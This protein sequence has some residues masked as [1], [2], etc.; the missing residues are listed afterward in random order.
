MS[1][2]TTALALVGALTLAAQL[3]AQSPSAPGPQ[4]NRRAGPP[5]GPRPMPAPAPGMMGRGPDVA[6]QLLAHTGELKL[7]DQQV[8]RLA[9]IARRSADRREGM[10]RSM[11]SL[12]TGR[13]MARPDSGRPR[14]G[15][16]P[17]MRATADRMRD[18]AHVDLRDALAVLSPDQ[19]ASAWEV[20]VSRG[21]APRGGL[22]FTGG[23]MRGG[24][25]R[26]GGSGFRGGPRGPGAGAPAGPRPDGSVR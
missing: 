13:G 19:L 2:M 21:P 22:G 4:P 8:T 24:P 14:G 17:E 20:V 1:R 18:Q 15:P 3:Q 10:R 16:P 9:A 23:P 25:G 7:S 6:E 26:G 11:D 5:A 12:M